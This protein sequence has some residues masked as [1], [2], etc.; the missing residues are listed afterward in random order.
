M[1]LC[2]PASGLLG[3]HSVLDYHPQCGPA[4]CESGQLQCIRG[5]AKTGTWPWLTVD[6]A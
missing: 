6:R 4:I 2:N 5:S 1:Q 3:I